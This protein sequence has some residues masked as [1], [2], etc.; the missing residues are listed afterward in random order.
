MKKLITILTAA[1]MLAAVVM[2]AYADT[3]ATAAAAA[4]DIKLGSGHAVC[5]IDAVY[6]VTAPG[7][8]ESA[9][10]T[11]ESIDVK[12]RSG[13][14]HAASNYEDGRLLISIASATPLDMSSSFASVTAKLS[15]GSAVVPELSLSLLQYD[16][17]PASSMA[18]GELKAVCDSSSGDIEITADLCDIYRLASAKMIVSAYD[19]SG[20]ML[21]SVIQDADL[22]GG[23]SKT[24]T[25]AIKGCGREADSIKLFLTDENYIPLNSGESVKVIK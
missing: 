7:V 25:A 4:A 2:P 21:K 19:A 8:G 23:A 17:Q 20:K 11:I 13:L 10:L 24:L 12:F 16:G 5:G 1:A 14:G 6:D 9:G 18:V 3:S 22:T 15:D